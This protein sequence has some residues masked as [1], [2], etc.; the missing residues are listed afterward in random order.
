LTTTGYPKPSAIATASAAV[1]AISPG[2]TG[3]RRAEEILSLVFVEIH[4]APF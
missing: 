2:G 4:R 3:I 1:R